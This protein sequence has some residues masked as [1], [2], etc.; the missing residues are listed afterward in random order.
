MAEEFNLSIYNDVYDMSFNQETEEIHIELK[1]GYYPLS[2]NVDLS[3]YYTKPQSDSRYKSINYVPNWSELFGKPTTFTPS[4]HTHTI[5]EVINLQSTLANK[6]DKLNAVNLGEILDT[7]LSIKMTPSAD[8]EIVILDSITGDAATVKFSSFGGNVDTSNLVPYTGANKHVNIGAYYFESSLGFKKTGG[9]S[10]QFL[11]A[12]GNTNTYGTTAGT[13]AE[14]NHT[15]TFTSITSKPTTLTGYGI[16]D[17]I[18][19][20]DT[21]QN[22][23]S[24][25]GRK[26][27]IN[28]IDNVLAGADKKYWVTV[29]KHK[30]IYNSVNYP[31]A[32]NTGDITLPQWEDSPVIATYD[33][34]QL[35]NNNYNGRISC[36][37]DEYLKVA[38]DFSADKTA[39]FDGYPY[40]TYYLN[41]Y[42]TETPDKAEVRCYN[43]LPIHTVGY[44]TGTFTDFINNNSSGAYIQQYTDNGN[45]QRR[46]IE[47]IIYG[48]PSHPTAL[49]QIEWKLQRP[50]FNKHSS[51]VSNFTTNKLYQILKLGNQTTDKIILNPNGTITSDSFKTPTGTANQALTANGGTFDLN[52]KA[53]LENGKIPATQLPSYVDDVLEFANLASFPATGESGKI[54]IAI[55]TNL[56]YRW[57]GSSY[58]V[59]SSSL[60]LGETSSTAYRGDRG[61]IAY[62]HS[63]ATGNPHNTKLEELTDLGSETPSIEDT[64]IILK[65]ESGGLWKKITF[66][67]FKN[68]FTTELAK[69]IN[70][71]LDTVFN[72]KNISAMTLTEFRSITPDIETIY[73]TEEQNTTGWQQVRYN[74]LGITIPETTETLVS[75]TNE[76][77]IELNSDS[78]FNL[79]DVA[80]TKI[81]GIFEKD[82]VI[83]KFNAGVVTPAT[84]N[85]WFKVI[86]KV[87]NVQ[88]AVSPVFYLTETSGTVEQIAHNFAL[89][90][91]TE[92]VTNGAT[93]HLKTSAAMTFNNPAISVVR[94]HKSTNAN[95]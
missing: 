86:L 16:T 75:L 54:Y 33:G 41:Y 58:V 23:N 62:T 65:K 34:A 15:H 55:D 39:Y 43:G 30:K 85:Q 91:P 78:T 21:I 51:F 56:T 5:S 2:N 90:V 11:M 27:Y 36:E 13:V 35:F 93:L 14:G 70:I 80:N 42:Y 92:M 6:E 31:K 88:T 76:N 26:L 22:T 64:D 52:T 48:H 77:F 59:M 9:T 69:K 45:Y 81:N 44:K 10:N 32:I 79:I 94:V 82:F 3:N 12:N 89:N 60:A 72:F 57:G 25:G 66:A 20:D 47:F 74:G 4:A 71:G 19:L 29:T 95:L 40:G 37:S 8:D 87:N 38:L 1:E 73:F 49:T 50:E 18:R 7:Q 53:D 68:W 17:G 67:N 24:F 83:I 84:A 63:Q 61:E 46:N 28:S